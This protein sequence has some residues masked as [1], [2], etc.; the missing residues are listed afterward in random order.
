MN[1]TKPVSEWSDDELK[2]S[3]MH[4]ILDGYAIRAQYVV[5]RRG[6]D[7]AMKGGDK[8]EA[9][10]MFELQ[11]NM[12][13]EARI[14]MLVDHYLTELVSREVNAMYREADEQ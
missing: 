1:M 11:R 10:L 9:A 8:A 3:I 14:D 5:L 4:L 2:D 6:S 13:T 12:K 7:A